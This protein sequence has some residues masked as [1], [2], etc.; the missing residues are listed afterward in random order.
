MEKKEENSK[1]RVGWSQIFETVE[2]RNNIAKYAK[3]A[4][5]EN[6]DRLEKELTL[7]K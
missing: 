6:L 3:N 7:I 2:L 5:E 4:N 1:T